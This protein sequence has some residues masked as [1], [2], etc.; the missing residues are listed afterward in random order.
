MPFSKNSVNRNRGENCFQIGN[1]YY[2][3]KSQI[4]KYQLLVLAGNGG[5]GSINVTHPE[6]TAI[7][8]HILFALMLLLGNLAWQIEP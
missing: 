1:D 6:S 5:E 4:Q 2:K 8:L 3:E 7:V